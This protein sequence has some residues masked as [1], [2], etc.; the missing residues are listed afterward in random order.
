MVKKTLLPR[1][2]CGWCFFCFSHEGTPRNTKPRP[3]S[4][5]LNPVII[6]IISLG[7]PLWRQGSA[8]QHTAVFA[9]GR[10]QMAGF[11]NRPDPL[12]RD[13]NPFAFLYIVQIGEKPDI[14][15]RSVIYFP[16]D[17]VSPHVLE[18][19]IVRR[20]G[21]AADPAVRGFS[22]PPVVDGLLHQGV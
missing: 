14:K 18:P 5:G 17:V 7:E 16:L 20:D 6:K 22:G 12:K 19:G 11:R 4:Q 15:N 8:T 1:C 9:G 2:L 21:P 13:G 10:R 3:S